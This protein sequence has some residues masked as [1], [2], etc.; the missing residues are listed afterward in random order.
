MT[1]MVKVGH[2]TCAHR[3]EMYGMLVVYRMNYGFIVGLKAK[4]LDRADPAMRPFF[5]N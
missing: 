1:F 3:L 2:Q 5:Q 4:C